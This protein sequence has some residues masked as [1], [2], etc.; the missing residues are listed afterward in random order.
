MKQALDNERPFALQTRPGHRV[1]GKIIDFGNGPIGVFV[2]GYRSDCDGSK[3]HA[4][5]SHANQRRYSWVRF[6]LT[7]HG[8]SDGDFA[9]FTI[10]AALRDLQ[11]V[12]EKLAPRPVVLVGSSLGGWL[13]VLAARRAPRRIREMLLIAPAFNF[14]QQILA[15]M[16]ASELAQWRRDGVRGFS[17]PYQGTT[18]T[19]GNDIVDDVDRYD[20]LREP[21]R[22]ACPVTILH[23]RHDE[24]VPVANSVRFA[25]QVRAPEIRLEVVA[26][27]D[28]R[29]TSAIPRMCAELDR[30]WEATTEP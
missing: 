2:H 16:P 28:H 23:G 14:V 4:L 27:G 5:A 13:S 30:I 9:R 11:T 12:L 10:T 21:V 8:R 7:G 6:D 18:Y 29:L 3:A 22:L 1:R 15:E 25:D 17:D 26:G 24:V 20:V 19:L